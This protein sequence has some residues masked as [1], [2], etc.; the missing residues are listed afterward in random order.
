MGFLSKLINRLISFLLVVGLVFSFKFFIK[1]T[2]EY[3]FYFKNNFYFLTIYKSPLKLF[4]KENFETS[5]DR[6]KTIIG[7]S[8]IKENNLG[9]IYI[10]YFLDNQPEDFFEKNYQ[11]EVKFFINDRLYHKEKRPIGNGLTENGIIFG[12]PVLKEGKNKN[13]K[14]VLKNNLPT[15]QKYFYLGKHLPYQEIYF[16]EK[17][18][19][20]SFNFFINFVKYKIWFSFYD[21]KSVSYLMILYFYLWLII[22]LII[23]KSNKKINK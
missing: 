21:K 18:Q 16:I 11:I 14:I 10:P 3:F 12:M 2:K 8:I 6:N 4:K 5:F 23:K 7:N 13:Y 9:L 17:K 1:Y 22:F 20:L 19:L 15:N